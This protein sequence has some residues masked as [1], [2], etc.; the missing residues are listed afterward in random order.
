MRNRNPGM[1]AAPRVLEELCRSYLNKRSS[2]CSGAC[3]SS[4]SCRSLL[5]AVV[6]PAML[7]EGEPYISRG[8]CRTRNTCSI[9]AYLNRVS[10]PVS[11]V[12]YT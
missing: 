4:S 6:C 10:A 11:S 8:Y 5:L 12:W 3:C 9:I 1:P 7:V 2:R